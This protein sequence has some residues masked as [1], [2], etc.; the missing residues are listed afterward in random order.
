MG[1]THD[2]EIIAEVAKSLNHSHPQIYFLFIGAGAKKKWLEEFITREQLT[3]ISVLPYRDASEKNISIN[4]G[5]VGIISYIPGMG[6]VSTP[7]RMYNQMAAGKPLIGITN[8]ESELARVINEEEVGWVVS[9]K[10]IIKLTDL[11]IEIE[12]H[13]NQ[14]QDRGKTA[15]R[16]AFTKYNLTKSISAYK[17]VIKS[18]STDKF[19]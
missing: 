15:N 14:V 16:I 6:G 2:V 9:P 1:R 10:D 7:S 18:A 17:Q 13:R 3:N 4:A 12:A 19:L 11:I 5:D 8:N